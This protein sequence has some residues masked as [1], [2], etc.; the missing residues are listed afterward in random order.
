MNRLYHVPLTKV[1]LSQEQARLPADAL[2]RGPE[3]FQGA[4]LNLADSFLANPQKMANLPE[5][6]RAVSGEAK[7]Q[8]EHLALARPEVLHEEVQRFLPF[9]IQ[10]QRLA[11]VVGHGLGELEVAV[12]VENG[13]ERDGGTGGSLEVGQVFQTAAGSGCQLLRAGQMLA[14][15][16]KGFGFLLEQAQFLEVVRRQAD[17]VALPGHGDLQGLPDPPGG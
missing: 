8:I 13:V 3:L 6:M 12:V 1:G 16:G 5:A 14:T 15:V 11:F 2:S 4:V 10:A 17:E 7:A 9:G